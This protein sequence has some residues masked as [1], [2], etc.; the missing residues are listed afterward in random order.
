LF[1]GNASSVLL[2]GNGDDVIFGGSKQSVLIGGSGQ[3]VIQGGFREDLLI[4]GN[5]SYD[6]SPVD[7]LAILNYWSGTENYA[8][9]VTKLRNGTGVPVLNGSTVSDDGKRD[10]LFGNNSLDYFFLSLNDISDRGDDEE[11]N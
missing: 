6:N 8:S 11:E 3:D 7:L 10:V 4:G 9:R 2:G 1:G 5:T